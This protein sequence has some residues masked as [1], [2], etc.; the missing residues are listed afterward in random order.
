MLIRIP[1]RWEMAEREA[2]PESVY[3]NRRELI[4]GAGFLGAEALA[5]GA[6]TKSLYPAKRNEA[7][8]LDRQ[9]TEEW[10]ATGYNNFYEFDPQDKQAVKDLVGSF[11][12][13]PWQIEV[14]GL[15]KPKTLDLDAILKQFPLE[16]RLYRFRCVEAWSMAVPW[17]GF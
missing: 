17:T 15:D 9:V 5:R 10:A 12:I 16:E 6:E 4:L 14:T 1:K 8:K 2:T 13:S 3:L 7:F 11:V